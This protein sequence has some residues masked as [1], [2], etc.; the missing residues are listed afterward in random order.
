VLD[1]GSPHQESFQ[2]LM[3]SPEPTNQAEDFE[4]FSNSALML[5]QMEEY[6]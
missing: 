5:L 3:L 6:I 1:K 2:K 4:V